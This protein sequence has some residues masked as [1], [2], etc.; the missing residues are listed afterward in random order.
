MHERLCAAGDDLTRDHLIAYAAGLG[1]DVARFTADL[2]GHV[3]EQAVNE[4][5]KR[6]VAGG[7]KLPPTLFINGVLFEGPRTEQGLRARINALL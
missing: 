4:D 1:L 2:D 6:A 5:F 3:H 7:V